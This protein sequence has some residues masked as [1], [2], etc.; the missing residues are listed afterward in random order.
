METHRGLS[1]DF[2]E[3]LYLITLRDEPVLGTLRGLNGDFLNPPIEVPE[4]FRDEVCG[5][6]AMAEDCFVR[7]E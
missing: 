5:V 2:L 3:S 7:G 6:R 1:G 4:L